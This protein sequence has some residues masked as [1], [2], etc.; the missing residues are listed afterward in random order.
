MGVIRRTGSGPETRL[1]QRRVVERLLAEPPRPRQLALLRVQINGC[2]GTAQ[3]M[4]YVADGPEFRP[5]FLLL[6]LLLLLLL[7]R[8]CGRGT[9]GPLRRK[10]KPATSHPPHGGGC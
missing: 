5:R 3:V 1:D 2:F 10:K 6:V 9:H 4:R 7:P 8:P